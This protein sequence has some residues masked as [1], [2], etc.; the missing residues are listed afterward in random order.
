MTASTM[1]RGTRVR[2]VALYT[3]PHASGVARE[4]AR[5]LGCSVTAAQRRIERTHELLIILPAAAE[6]VGRQ[7]WLRLWA[8]RFDVARAAGSD[9][10]FSLSALRTAAAADNTEDQSLVDLLTEDTTE[11]LDRYIRDL[12]HEIAVKSELLVAVREERTRRLAAEPA[13]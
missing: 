1:V 7:D 4:V 5:R 3:R 9:I 10:A 13:Q 6:A 8:T 12:E 2:E 11:N